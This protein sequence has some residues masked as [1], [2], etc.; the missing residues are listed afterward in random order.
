MCCWEFHL[1]LLYDLTYTFLFS[2]NSLSLNLLTSYP[3]NL[4]L[5]ILSVLLFST[6]TLVPILSYFSSAELSR[7]FTLSALLLMQLPWSLSHITS[8]LPS[9]L[10]P[11]PF[12][13]LPLLSHLTKG[14]CAMQL[15]VLQQALKN[16]DICVENCKSEKYIMKQVF[17]MYTRE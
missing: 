17:F 9:P 11:S 7:T 1:S 3:L 8:F 6:N 14:T 5:N 10:C 13:T 12:F 16:K 2:V 4:T 15:P